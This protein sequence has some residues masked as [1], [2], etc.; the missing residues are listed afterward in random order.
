ML[1]AL[2]VLA[3]VAGAA[4]VV[5]TFFSAV[6]TFVVPRGVP[7]RLTRLVFRGLR[8]LF[9]VRVKL[10]RT[11]EAGESVMAWY[12]PLSLLLLVGTWL[13]L[14][15]L[16][17]TLV[18]R[19]LGVG[20]WAL[21]FETAGSSLTTLGFVPV[22]GL[23]RQIAAFVDAGIGL[24]LLALLITYLPTIY[25]SFQRREAIVSRAAMQAGTP[26]SGVSLLERF[27][28][29]SGF[30]GLEDQVWQPWT[31]GFVDIEESHTTIAA[32]PFFRSPRPDR[33]WVTSA[34]AVLDAA[35]L[36][37]SITTLPREPSAELCIRAGFLALRHIAEFFGIAY[38]E[39]PTR[40]DPI[41]IGRDEWEEV[42]VRL[43]A[44]GVPVRDDKDE[45]WLDFMGWRVNY[46]AVLLAMAGL[47][48][49]PYAPWISDRGSTRRHRPPIIGR[50]RAR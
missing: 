48:M 23:H 25:S 41:S 31:S 4:I 13:L 17:F 36:R 10:A 32:L 47:V 20:T 21:A 30:D 8:G 9:D 3:V 44:I 46:D 5:A 33:H 50:Y 35:A 1:V 29:I 43:A 6:A 19:G 2:H 7:A 42:Y 38:D 37:A 11:Y 12:A 27:H 16:G 49:A 45:A 34:G 24:L 39:D 18:F 26:P 28:L 14:T 15:M 40:G 22:V